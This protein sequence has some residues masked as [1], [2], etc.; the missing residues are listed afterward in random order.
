MC[1]LEPSPVESAMCITRRHAASSTVDSVTEVGIFTTQL[2]LRKYA[3]LGIQTL[4]VYE[5]CFSGAKELLYCCKESLAS[6]SQ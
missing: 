1:S 2:G 6:H 5:K 3:D 4:P